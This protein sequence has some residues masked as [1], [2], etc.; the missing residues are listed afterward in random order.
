M[1]YRFSYWVIEWNAL[2]H[3][4]HMS[5]STKEITIISISMQTTDRS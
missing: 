1:S 2:P 5:N 3:E 4:G